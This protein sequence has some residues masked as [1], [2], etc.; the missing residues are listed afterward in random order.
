M[1]ANDRPRTDASTEGP[2]SSRAETGE[3]AAHRGRAPGATR[4]RGSTSAQTDER[5]R[6]R[7]DPTTHSRGLTRPPREPVP[8]RAPFTQRLTGR[9]GDVV[10]EA[11]KSS[12]AR[13]A[14]GVFTAM[15]LLFTGLLEL[16]IATTGGHRTPFVD[17]LFTAVSAVCVTGLVTVDTGTHWSTFGLVVLMAAMKVGGL[18]VLTLASLL[19]LSVMR[20]MGLAQRII[21]ASETRSQ[22]L[23]EVGGVLGTIVIAST[24]FELLTFL[25]LTPHMLATEHEFWPSIFTGAFYAISAFNNAGF[26]PEAAGTAQYL[27]DPWFSIPIA[28]AV[29]MGSLGFPVVLVLVRAWRRPSRW[30]LHAKLTLATSAILFGTGFLAILTMEWSNPATLGPLD[31]GSKAL[32][33]TFASVMPRSGGFS[34]LDIGALYPQTRLVMDL[35]MFI[36]GG[37]GSTGGGIKVTTFALLVLSI[38]AEAR[39]D[40]DVE[41]LGRRIPHDTIRQAIAVL[42]MS[43]VLVF[44][45]TLVMLTLTEFTL[46]QVVFEVLSAYGTVGLSTGITPDLPT[47]AKYVLVLAMYLGR[48]GPMTL[49]AAL[50]LRERSRVVRLPEERPIVG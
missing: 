3:P 36:G 41:V 32:A 22:K 38:L 23:S 17:A 10:G 40:R 12:P 8:R 45:A 39:G 1:S 6:A 14:L 31:L 34:T 20:H 4:R 19:G 21:T 13:L 24:S 49:G 33:S 47:G 44:V 16:P 35:L 50:A 9:I 27:T 15:I 5:M 30:T 42:V 25:A 43:T 18:G 11:A 29:F 2:A 46:D 37:S 26:V 28:L 48:I 7:R